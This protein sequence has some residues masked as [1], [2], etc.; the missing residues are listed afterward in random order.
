MLV[1][2]EQNERGREGEDGHAGSECVLRLSLPRGK[3][4]TKARAATSHANTV[5]TCAGRFLSLLPLTIPYCRATAFDIDSRF[6][7]MGTMIGTFGCS[8]SN[9]EDDLTAT[10][11]P[12]VR[13]VALTD[14]SGVKKQL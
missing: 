3:G 14:G 11:K 2:T 13:K 6:Q 12:A 4:T 7:S 10:S 5:L 8:S 9:F 1:T